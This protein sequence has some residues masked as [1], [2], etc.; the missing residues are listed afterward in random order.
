MVLFCDADNKSMTKT[1]DRDRSLSSVR[2]MPR[3]L[4]GGG[5][6]E[7]GVVAL[8]AYDETAPAGSET[9]AASTSV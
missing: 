3:S 2:S 4:L 5:G 1:C 7:R 8:R 6:V 9:S